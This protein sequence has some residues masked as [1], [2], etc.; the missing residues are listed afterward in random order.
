MVFGD[1]QFA[2]IGRSFFERALEALPDGALLT[3]VRVGLIALTKSEF[4]VT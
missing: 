3:D 1:K 2:A 4:A